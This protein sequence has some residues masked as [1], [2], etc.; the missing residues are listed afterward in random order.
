MKDFRRAR[1]GLR[2]AERKDCAKRARWRSFR[3]G[4]GVVAAESRRWVYSRSSGRRWRRVVGSL[5]VTGMAIVLK[6]LPTW[7]TLALL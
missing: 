3:W 6:S 1:L 7:G 4:R 2:R 5:E